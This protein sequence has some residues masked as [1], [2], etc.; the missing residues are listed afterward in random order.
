MSGRRLAL[1]VVLGAGAVALLRMLCVPVGSFREGLTHL[2]WGMPADSVR[3]VLGDANRICTDP[4][5]EHV[6]LSVSPDTAEVRRALAAFTA[7]RWVY[8][9]P[10]PTT[11]VPR[12]DRPG[13]RAPVM[14]TELGFDAAGRLRWYVRET[15]Q[16]PAT[17]DPGVL[18]P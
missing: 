15:D 5:V 9:R 14:A 4:G 18:T 1:I 17:I 16:T 7:E 8:A 10:R 13:C 3:E 11:P 2:T 12:D 6:K